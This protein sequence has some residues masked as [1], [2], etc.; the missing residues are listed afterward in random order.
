MPLANPAHLTPPKFRDFSCSY[1]ANSV[2][3]TRTAPL[4]TKRRKLSHQPEFPEENRRLL[5]CFFHRSQRILAMVLLWLYFSIP[6]RVHFLFCPASSPHHFSFEIAACPCTH[7]HTHCGVP[8]GSVGFHR[9][10]CNGFPLWLASV[11]AVR[12]L[13]RTECPAAKW[14]AR[15]RRKWISTETTTRT[16]TPA[17]MMTTTTTMMII[18]IIT[19]A[20]IASR[21]WN[22]VNFGHRPE[23]TKLGA[24]GKHGAVCIRAR[25]AS[26]WVLLGH[27]E[28]LR[29]ESCTPQMGRGPGVAWSPWQSGLRR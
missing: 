25:V 18:I 29:T 26:R 4:R 23:A 12:S 6:T 24:R 21:K 17:R 20:I 8:F 27:A 5:F 3:S 1:L 16:R 2:R 10:H 22:F 14:F 19:R 11:A 7:T 28:S 9:P 15:K 13:V